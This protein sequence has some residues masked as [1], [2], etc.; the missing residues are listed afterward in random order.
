M[1]AATFLLA[2]P[3]HS[4]AK[5]PGWFKKFESLGQPCE[6]TKTWATSNYEI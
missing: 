1:A 6:K 4:T 3:M 5:K 2:L